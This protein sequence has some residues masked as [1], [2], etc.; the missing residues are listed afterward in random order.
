MSE[1]H[2][3]TDPPLAPMLVEAPSLKNS[4]EDGSAEDPQ[5]PG[6]DSSTPTTPVAGQPRVGPVYTSILVISRL[7]SLASFYYIFK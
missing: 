7:F 3:Q 6:T 4:T 1:R 5:Q 2:E